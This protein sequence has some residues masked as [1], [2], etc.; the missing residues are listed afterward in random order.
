MKTKGSVILLSILAIMS[1]MIGTAGATTCELSWLSLD[2]ENIGSTSRS[3]SF[4]GTGTTMDVS[5]TLSVTNFNYKVTG[6]WDWPAGQAEEYV[7]TP[8]GYLTR[9]FSCDYDPWLEPAA[10]CSPAGPD[11]WVPFQSGWVASLD[12][13]AAYGHMN[14]WIKFPVSAKVLNDAYR[15]SMAQL[16]MSR[17][18]KIIAPENDQTFAKPDVIVTVTAER[19]VISPPNHLFAIKGVEAKWPGGSG[20]EARAFDGAK[21]YLTSGNTLIAYFNLEGKN[22]WDGRWLVKAH[23]INKYPDW[24][25]ETNFSVGKSPSSQLAGDLSQ[26][27]VE[28]VKA[29]TI[30]QPQPNHTY[31]LTPADVPLRITYQKNWALHVALA[32]R[33]GGSGQ[34]LSLKEIV[35][36]KDD[37]SAPGYFHQ[38]IGSLAL[39]SNAAIAELKI[40][41]W[42]QE[43][44]NT[45]TPGIPKRSERSSVVTRVIVDPLEIESPVEGQKYVAPAQVLFSIPFT[46]PG[47]DVDLEKYVEVRMDWG[48]TDSDISKNMVAKKFEP[49]TKGSYT[50]T[51]VGNKVLI[52]YSCQDIGAYRL[53]A[54]FVIP[55]TEFTKSG[56]PTLTTPWT[57]WRRIYLMK[58]LDLGSNK[59]LIKYSGATLQSTLGSQ[60]FQSNNQ[61][62]NKGKQIEPNL[63]PLPKP[64][65]LSKNGTV[66]PSLLLP[67]PDQ[68]IAR[69]GPVQLKV[70]GGGDL[71]KLDW[72]IE[73]R[74]FDGQR[75]QLLPVSTNRQIHLVEAGNLAS[76][77]FKATRE[78]EYRIRLCNKA[79]NGKWSDWRSF[80]VGKAIAKKPQNIL[81]NTSEKQTKLKTTTP[82]QASQPE[83]KNVKQP[84]VSDHKESVSPVKT[85]GKL[86]PKVQ[87]KTQ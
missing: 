29:P 60:G 23:V 37:T 82:I 6:K 1:L 49:Y 65:V 55:D 34:Y 50:A 51:C 9:R 79:D 38:N 20:T 5:H 24:T 44:K 70:I 22:L 64:A 7:S 3:Y 40:S 57:D 47:I 62:L 45:H 30:H 72:Q 69:S 39:L 58:E 54:R 26:L 12:F 52:K 87:L 32:Y 17:S 83:K 35:V 27:Q 2:S 14:N 8:Y 75:Y 4:S 18:L 25:A 63:H 77:T 73:Y 84:E 56:L 71:D 41:A 21:N 28:E 53:R 15:S 59:D 36:G 42:V 68:K 80:T 10:S 85:P 74:P 78:G 43:E 67:R 66:G 81:D 86:T 33:Q 61:S 16:V 13:P 46:Y 48:G 31:H 11:Q 19:P 76:G